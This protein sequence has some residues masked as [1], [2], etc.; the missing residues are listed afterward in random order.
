VNSSPRNSSDKSLQYN[1]KV[2]DI[3][4]T[5]KASSHECMRVLLNIFCPTAKKCS[6]IQHAIDRTTDFLKLQYILPV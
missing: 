2:Q 4:P 1:Y 3:V 6:K 5:S